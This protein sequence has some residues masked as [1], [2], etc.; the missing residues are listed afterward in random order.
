MANREEIPRTTPT[1]IEH[2]IQQVRDTNLDQGSK[3][4]IERLLRTV[5]TL[6]ELLQRRNT[7]IKKLREMIFG[8]RTERHHRK[9][10]EGSDKKSKSGTDEKDSPESLQDRPIDREQNSVEGEEK[11]RAKGHGRRAA[12]EY[13][14]ARKVPCRHEQLKAGD[15]C[16]SPLCGGRL[17]D[18]NEPTMLLQFV[19]T[20]LITATNY[21]REVL[22]CAKCQDRYVAPCDN[23]GDEI[24]RR[25]AMASTGWIAGDDGSSAGRINDVGKVRSDRGCGIG[26]IPAVD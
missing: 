3:D 13:S 16:P 8:R 1:E 12:S 9:K 10:V 21:E 7:S 20:P 5:L 15:N 26:C 23:R 2:L 6:V 19:G 4:K 24:R 18:L 14:G 17:Y 25:A 11:L 22:R